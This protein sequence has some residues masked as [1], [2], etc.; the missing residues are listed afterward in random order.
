MSSSAA[1]AIFHG[2]SALDIAQDMANA[3]SRL[4]AICYVAMSPS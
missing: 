1:G 3:G 4:V 2:L